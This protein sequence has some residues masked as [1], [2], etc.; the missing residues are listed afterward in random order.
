MAATNR[1]VARD[2]CIKNDKEIFPTSD[3]NEEFEWGKARLSVNEPSIG[4]Q[5]QI[6]KDSVK[7]VLNWV[8]INVS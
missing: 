5:L 1:Y 7:K 6:D 4:S 3:A 2:K 8:Q